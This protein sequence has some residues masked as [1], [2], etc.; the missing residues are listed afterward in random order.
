M[1][2]FQECTIILILYLL[3]QKGRGQ[4]NVM[5][6]LKAKV[7]TDTQKVDFHFINGERLFLKKGDDMHQV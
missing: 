2:V 5:I 6:V 4:I 3:E 1:Y 7:I